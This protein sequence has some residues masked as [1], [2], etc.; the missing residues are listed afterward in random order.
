M[1]FFWRAKLVYAVIIMALLGYAFVPTG[2]VA[3]AA[4]PQTNP[5]APSPNTV[6]SPQAPLAGYSAY[7]PLVMSDK[8][9]TPPPVT[10][11]RTP[12]GT[13]MPTATPTGPTSTPD[14]RR[15]S[16]P[17]VQ[18]PTPTVG[19][20]PTPA[21]VGPEQDWPQLGRDAQRTNVSTIQV[22]P[23]YC[24][25]WKWYEVPF[26]SRVQPVVANGY[27]YMGSLNGMLY[28][29][30]ANTG[31]A[32]WSYQTNGPLRHSAGVAA[33]VV[34]VSSYDGFT[35]GLN[36]STGAL[37]WKVE[38]GSS[39]T[40]PL[41][42]ASRNWAYVASTN[43]KLVA[44]DLATGTVKWT[45]DSK[46]PVLTSASLSVDNKIVYFG[47]EDIKAIAL[48]AA[49]GALK[50]EQK[51]QGQSLT[52][53]YPVV[54]GDSV[55]YRSQP[56]NFFHT[57]LQ[58]EGD[59]VMDEAGAVAG[60]IEADWVNVKP[61]IVNHLNAKPWQQTFFVLNAADGKSRGTAPMLYTYGNQDTPNVPVM[62]PGS[63]GTQAYVTYRARK[64][65]QTDAPSVHVTTK[66]DAELGAMNLSTLDI[67][68][69]T[70]NAKFT[71]VGEWRM[72]SDEPAMLTRGGDIL[73]IDSWERLGGF[74]L[75]DKLHYHAGA[76]GNPTPGCNELCNGS[77]RPFFPLSGTGPSWPFPVT[78]VGEGL[79]RGG[80][81]I[82]S[83]M[84]YW[85]VNEGGIAAYTHQAS[86]ACA[87]PKVYGPT[88]ASG[89][90]PAEAPPSVPQTRALADYVTLDLTTP[91]ASPP[92]DL[93]Q[94]LRNEISAIVNSGGHLMP[95]YLERGFS[96]TLVWPP[97]DAN[98]PDTLPRILYNSHGN[99]YWFDPGELLYTMA[100]A[101]P[102][103]DSALQQQTKTYVAAEMERF[104][105]LDK[106]PFKDTDANWLSAGIARERY[107]VPFR[108][109]LNN[110][111]SVKANLDTMY[112]LWLWSKNTGD[113][114]YAC[115]NTAQIKS[116][117]NDTK[118]NL[119]YYADLGGL[120]GYARL[121]QGLVT[122]KCAGWSSTDVTAA[123]QAA[124]DGLTA[125]LNFT[126]YR[127]R[128]ENDFLDPREKNT[129]WSLPVF[130][131]LTPEVGL[132]LSERFDDAARAELL[133]KEGS[134]AMPQWYLTKGGVQ[135]EEGETSYLGPQT[136]WSHFLA[137]AYITK[138][139]N[140]TLR[141]WLDRPWAKGD[142]Y[143]IQKV[144]A[145][146]QAP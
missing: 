76:I 8:G 13:R 21:P 80:A 122:Q 32:M 93:V 75:V 121:A 127:D 34:V 31:E 135:G 44:L 82:A 55:I 145:A 115:S 41:M 51:L 6:D 109:E 113:W 83:N 7:L 40:A 29:R 58:T 4:D 57:L 126:T 81:V 138:D 78:L 107:D 61:K 73:W 94:R 36:A 95:F 114:S 25:A 27:F 130:F 59:S 92:T 49:T 60:S 77:D 84:V 9:A 17:T 110:W 33:G 10:A 91:K 18:P 134:T 63:N 74:D 142:L 69:L 144:V 139:T 56:I 19:V 48:D 99:V 20:P 71:G 46:A 141:K 116:L 65:I 72:T 43:G 66:Y 79:S 129:G 90:T 136:A 23:P 22:D 132:Y 89:P 123:Q 5:Q 35:Y 12:T 30:N 54:I 97:G 120:I 50:W 45:Y 62:V 52:D 102:Y 100:M 85:V 124:V 103:L 106:L 38:T 11:T 108:A 143:S 2:T 112:G 26:A 128:A 42:D 37:N 24:Y 64:G 16:I 86:G 96:S 3:Q 111:P 53:R 14:P 101:Y 140:A 67:T 39:L 70:A 125:G 87:P 131:G 146:I 118:A 117:Y 105:P 98:S 68:G 47:N 88:S 133:G 15:T 119:R 104:T 137:R 1:R 28:A